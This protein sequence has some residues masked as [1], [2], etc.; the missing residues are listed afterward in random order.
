MKSRFA[1][2]CVL[3]CVVSAGC[4][5]PFLNKDKDD[6]S[7][8]PT[9][10]TGSATSMDA[11]AGTWSSVTVGNPANGCGDVKYTVTPTTTSSAN[12]TFSATCAGNIAV[13]GSGAGTL[14]GNVISWTAN[15]LVAQGGVN[16]PFAFTNSK[17]TLGS[18]GQIAVNYTG[19]VCGIPV[20]GT[21]TVKK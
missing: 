16:C 7:G 3:A 18:D 2:A 14:N 10:P 6:E 9:G 8:N 19:T 15:G 1:A 12:I 11:F 20:S 21:E 4:N 13:T 17:A 5:I